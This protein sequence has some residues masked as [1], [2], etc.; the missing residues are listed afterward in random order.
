VGGPFWS[1]GI[2]KVDHQLV[3][4][5][6]EALMVL[7][8]FE[9]LPK[10]EIPP[11]HIWWSVDMLD[12]WFEDVGKRRKRQA[13]GKKSTYDTADEV[14]SMGNQLVDREDLIPR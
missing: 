10:E 2:D 7:A 12:Q 3:Q 8:W 11:R 5:V 1:E 4:A 6:N 13:S 14:P 9:N